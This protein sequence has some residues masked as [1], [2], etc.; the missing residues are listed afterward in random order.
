M[1]ML[2]NI[3]NFLC[4]SGYGSAEDS[5][6]FK[7][8]QAHTLVRRVDVCFRVGCVAK[9]QRGQSAKL[10]GQSSALTIGILIEELLLSSFFHRKVY[11]L[12]AQLFLTT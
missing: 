5:R 2:K 10:V 11:Q 1:R 6:G 8:V 3:F 7:V 4:F 9:G 12:I